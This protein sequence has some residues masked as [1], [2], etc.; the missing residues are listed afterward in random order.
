MHLPDGFLTAP[1]S[2]AMAIAT[3]GAV[4]TAV[5]RVS[6][7]EQETD[8]RALVPLMGVSAAFIFTA[9]MF[10]FPIAGGTTGHLLG[11]A[12]ATALLGPWRAILVM[13]VVVVI[14]AMMFADGGVVVLGANVFNLGIAGCL[15][16]GLV[17]PAVQ[18]LLPGAAGRTAAVAVAAWLSVQLAALLTSLEMSFTPGIAWQV[19]VP[20]MLAVHAVIGL[21]EALLTV[22]AYNLV[23]K[24]RAGL[25]AE[26][27]PW[28][29]SG[30]TGTEPWRIGVVLLLGLVVVRLAFPHPDGLEFVAQQQGF[31][32]LARPG[33]QAA[34]LPD[35]AIPGHEA[36]GFDWLGNYFSALLGMVVCAGLMFGLGAGLQRRRAV[37]EAAE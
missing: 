13:T 14:Q 3:V 33:L 15:L 8:T 24:H 28:A 27:S 19:V 30:G 22:A 11:A 6:Q 16:S 1:V 29:F 9:Q 23:V 4:A 20:A 7:E 37:P 36:S 26:D 17:I 10:N 2:G 35:Y 31:E 12:L 18:R 32:A 25:V 21:G 34:P 5:R